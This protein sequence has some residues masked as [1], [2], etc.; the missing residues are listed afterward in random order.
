MGRIHLGLGLLKGKRGRF[1]F[2]KISRVKIAHNHL[3]VMMRTTKLLSPDIPDTHLSP[4]LL[5]H[6]QK[7]AAFKKRRL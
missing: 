6:Y 5:A 7:R 3:A 4:D 1:F 2:N